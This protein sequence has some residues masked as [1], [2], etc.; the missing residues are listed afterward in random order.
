MD[1]LQPLQEHLPYPRKHRQCQL[2]GKRAGAL[3]IALGCRIADTGL[4]REFQPR[5][6]MAEVEQILQHDQRI[7]AVLIKAVHPVECVRRIAAQHA[8]QQV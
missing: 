8:L 7:G 3:A 2:L 1:L 4:G 5:Q 6:K